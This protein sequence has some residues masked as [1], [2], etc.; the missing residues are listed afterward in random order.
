MNNLTEQELETTSNQYW[1]T[2]YNDLEALKQ[3]KL[4]QKVILQGYL[5]DRAVDLTSMLAQDHVVNSGQRSAVMEDLIAIS[6]LED[7]FIMVDNLGNIP[8]EDEE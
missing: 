2:M 4:F 8:T 7:F 3:N 6:S 5:K 1:V